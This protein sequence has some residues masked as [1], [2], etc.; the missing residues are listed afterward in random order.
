MALQLLSIT[1]SV[2]A[3]GSIQRYQGKPITEIIANGFFTVDRK[4]TVKYWNRAAEELLGVRAGD[5]VGKN[6]W[7]EF[8]GI[9]PLDFYAFYHKAFLQ[10][11]PVHFEEYWGEM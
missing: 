8:A 3:K 2:K 5:I 7:S 10:D 9:L 1:N 11:V 6:L 4:W